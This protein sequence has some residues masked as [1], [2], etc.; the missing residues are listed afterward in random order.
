MGYRHRY[1]YYLTGLPGWIRFGFSPGWLGRSPLPPTA[2]WL[3]QSGLLPQYMQWLQTAAPT[4][5]PP[6]TTPPTGAQAAPTSF[7]TSFAPQ[8]TK[9]QEKQMLEQQVKMLESQLEAMRKRLEELS[10]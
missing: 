3:L 1:M 2:Q 6:T 4:M 9:E 8:L 7:P 5:I 10:K